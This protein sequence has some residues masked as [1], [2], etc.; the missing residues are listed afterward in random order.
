MAQFGKGSAKRSSPSYLMV[1]VGISVVLFFLGLLGLIVIYA[2]KLSEYFKEN[3]E[4]N[5][6][7]RENVSP[8]D[9][10]AL[11]EYVAAQPYVKTYN[12]ITKDLAKERYLKDGDK[13]WGALLDKNPL[14]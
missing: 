11:V 7:I 6:F 4:M 3:I 14:P 13:D 2:N 5:V 9:S 8:K 12:Y 1:I 10:A